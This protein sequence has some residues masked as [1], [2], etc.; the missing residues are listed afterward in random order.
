MNV[1]YP[2]ALSLKKKKKKANFHEEWTCEG[3]LCS[4]IL[5]LNFQG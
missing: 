5:I 1:H 2:Q 3:Y 4:L